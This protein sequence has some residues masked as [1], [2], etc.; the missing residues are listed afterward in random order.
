VAEGGTAA[1]NPWNTTLWMPGATAYNTFG[2]NE[3]VYNY[4]NAAVGIVATVDTLTNG[5]Y[6]A[7]LTHFKA[8]QDGLGVC[9]AVDASRWGTH[10]AAATYRRLYPAPPARNLFL[11]T[12]YMHGADVV[13]VQHA[14]QTRG[15]NVGPAQAD[16]IYGP[17]TQA[18]VKRFQGAHGLTVDGIVGPLTRHALDIA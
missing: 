3:H 4:P 9:E 5:Y 13:I 17:T 7:I 1:F 11:M 6:P 18:A 12:P 16:G 15:Y 2:N 10:G 8:G 14:L